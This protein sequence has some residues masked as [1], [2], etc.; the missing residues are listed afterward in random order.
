MF[1]D[2]FKNIAHEHVYNRKYS[3]ADVPFILH[4]QSAREFQICTV[5]LH[6]AFQYGLLY[7]TLPV[8][9]LHYPFIFDI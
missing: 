7:S 4:V 3:L 1:L 5:F 6:F 9:Y 2:D 8:N